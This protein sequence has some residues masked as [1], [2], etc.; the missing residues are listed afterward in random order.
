[1]NWFL[2]LAIII[3]PASSRDLFLARNLEYITLSAAPI[4]LLYFFT[5]FPVKNKNQISRYCLSE[6]GQEVFKEDGTCS[7]LVG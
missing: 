5:I 2:G 7:S 4:L 3:A 1:M 6:V